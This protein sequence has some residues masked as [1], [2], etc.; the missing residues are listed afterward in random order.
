[1]RK[2]ILSLA[3]AAVFAAPGLAYAD[4]GFYIDGSVGRASVDDSGIDDNDTGFRIGGG[5]RFLENFGAEVGYLDLG[6]VEEE[7]AIGGAT[8]SVEVDGLYA[9]VSGRIPLS[10]D[11]AGFFLSARAG[12]LFWDAE[13]R[14]RAGT[15]TVPFDDSDNDFYVGVGG[16]YDF[17][18]QFGVSLT[19]DRYKVGDS[20]ADFNYSV[21]G[22][23]GEVRF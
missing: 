10:D 17:N 23:T 8:G 19:Y 2:S 5:W 7:V 12:L 14:V 22:A 13:G 20:G 1:M 15:V 16:G 18:E 4:E 3:V 9:G 6:K 11:T 21:I